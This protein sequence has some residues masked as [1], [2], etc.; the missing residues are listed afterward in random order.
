MGER[1]VC[2][3]DYYV[4]NACITYE[5]WE[6]NCFLVCPAVCV[7]TCCVGGLNATRTVYPLPNNQ[8]LLQT[9]TSQ[10]CTE[11]YVH[12]CTLALSITSEVGII[13]L[14][15]QFVCVLLQVH[16]IQIPS[17]SAVK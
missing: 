12:V 17:L 2:G 3:R 14:P 8:H 7:C 11:S 5:P 16:C 6:I 15:L 1:L 4:K 13:I 10:K 9:C